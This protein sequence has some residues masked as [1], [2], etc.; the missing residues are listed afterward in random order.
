MFE[1]LSYGFGLVRDRSNYQSGAEVRYGFWIDRP[2]IPQARQ[3]ADFRSDVEAPFG[4]ANELFSGTERD[5]DGGCAGG[6][7]DDALGW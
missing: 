1:Q 7:G 5:E 3:V 6:K 2:T 4:N